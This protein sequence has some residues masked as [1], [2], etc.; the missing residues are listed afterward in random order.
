MASSPFFSSFYRDRKSSGRTAVVT[1]EAKAAHRELV[2]AARRLA[3]STDEANDL[4][5]DALVAA[6]DR[7][8]T[9]W[10]S[11]AHRDWLRGVVRKRWAFVARSEIRRR[12]REAIF[13]TSEHGNSAWDWEERFLASLPRS[14]RVV[15]MLA[16]A[17]LCATEIRW[18]LGL[19]ETAMRKRLSELRRAVRA[20]EDA[21]LR[22]APGPQFSFGAQR[23]SLLTLL[24]RQRDPVIATHDPDG[25]TILL[26]WVAHKQGT[27]GNSE[28]KELSPCQKQT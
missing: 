23:A 11:P 2:R 7:G 18:L 24:K 10:A 16:R 28:V 27:L 12:R 5:Q 26:R 3:G 14:L 4:A 9:D 1:P 19:S 25:H 21:P 15:A 13:E 6:L 22:P 8:L 17:D 20:A